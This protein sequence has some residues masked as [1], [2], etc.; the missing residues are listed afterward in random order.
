MSCKKIYATEIKGVLNNLEQ[1]IDS[2]NHIFDSLNIIPKELEWGNTQHYDEITEQINLLIV[3]ECLYEEAPWEKLLTTINHFCKKNPDIEI[4]FAY[5]KRYK[6]QEYF[7]NEFSNILFQII[8][9]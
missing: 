3:C 2:N 4:I 5:K 6:S 1:N 7:L 8:F 9:N